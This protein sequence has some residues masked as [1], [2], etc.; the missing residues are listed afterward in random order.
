MP[1][2]GMAPGLGTGAVC[3]ACG[4]PASNAA[5]DIYRVFGSDGRLLMFQP[6]GGVKY[7][8]RSHPVES[9][10]QDIRTMFSDGADV[11][12]LLAREEARDLA[13][14]CALTAPGELE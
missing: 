14:R 1:A 2:A 8:C 4:A 12:E 10:S 9:V 11:K 7:G 13:N 5:R 3:D 6:R